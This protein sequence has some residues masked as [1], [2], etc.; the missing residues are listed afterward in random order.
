MGI[1]RHQGR[2]GGSPV[3]DS[4]TGFPRRKLVR[5]LVVFGVLVI[6]ANLALDENAV[7][8]SVREP[9]S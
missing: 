8:E 4:V 2:S 6:A 9:Y 7:W 5:F 3:R 1:N